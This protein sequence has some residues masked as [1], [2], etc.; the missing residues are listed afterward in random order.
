[1]YKRLIILTV[2]LCYASLAF[3]IGKPSAMWGYSGSKG[4][5]NWATLHPS[6]HMC[7]SGLR[8]SPIDIYKVK[9]GHA[10]HLRFHYHPMPLVLIN[11]SITLK[12]LVP[13]NIKDEFIIYQ[14]EKFYLHDIHVHCPSEHKLNHAQYPLELHL[15]HTD[16]KGHFLVLAVFM[17]E[18][19]ENSVLGK[20]L[21]NVPDR[22]FKRTV[23]A[24]ETVNPNNVLPKHLDFYEYAGSLTTPPCTENV[25]WLVMATPIQASKKQIKLFSER[26]YSNNARPVQPLNLR[27][28]LLHKVIS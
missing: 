13:E 11:N 12:A 5:A 10:E 28:V 2:A 24:D 1:M 22:E 14:N 19:E 17:R 6:Y 23:I 3:A 20:N 18:G 4:P 9:Y 16:N 21:K 8:Q 25:Q 26:L 27:R 15:V 7:D